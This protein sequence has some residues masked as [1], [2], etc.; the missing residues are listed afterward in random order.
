MGQLRH[1][2]DSLPT[3]W[4]IPDELWRRIEPILLEDAPPMPRV[5][6][7]AEWNIPNTATTVSDQRPSQATSGMIDPMPQPF[8]KL[9]GRSI[10]A[11]ASRI[12]LTGYNR[13]LVR[14]LSHTNWLLPTAKV[15][16]CPLW[17][18]PTAVDPTRELAL[19]E[20]LISAYREANAYEA[21][22]QHRTKGIWNHIQSSM[23]HKLTLA[24]ENNDLP[25]VA[26]LLPCM[27]TQDFMYGIS[28]GPLYRHARNRLG[29]QIWSLKCLDSLVSLAEY[30]GVVRTECPEQGV[31]GHAFVDG[32]DVLLGRIE[33]AAGI[34]LGF[35][36]VGGAYG[37]RISSSL[38][39]MES[40]EHIY[41]ALRIRDIVDA[42]CHGGNCRCTGD[43]GPVQKAPDVNVVE[44]GAGFG[45]TAYWLL[46]LRGL[47]GRYTV[48][49]LPLTNV[50]QGYFLARTLGESRVCLFGESVSGHDGA[51]TVRVMPTAFIQHNCE[52]YDIMINENSMPEMPAETVAGYLEWA[53]K[54]RIHTFY[55]YNQ[56]AF[57]PFE[58]TPQTSVREMVA[59]A[60]GFRLYSRNHSWLRRG[61]AEEVY[62]A[63]ESH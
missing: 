13:M 10:E 29:A 15:P 44:I 9:V 48:V 14:S 37:I 40:P 33:H 63:E 3:I 43:R 27:F 57:S 47:G 61:Y 50:L 49:D 54:A 32:L 11:L 41:V 4:E 36:E 18:S 39:T 58:G 17:F 52:Q 51:L 22:S 28:S 6:D 46:Q 20:R 24:I 42:L 62:L 31:V 38:V 2:K 59:R 34:P 19:C 26:R 30:L 7:S 35:P 8:Y 55:S 5:H 12:G 60:G 1:R 53:R 23:G 25:E 21:D 56:E 16:F 45:G